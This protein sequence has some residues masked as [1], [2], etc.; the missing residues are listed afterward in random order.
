MPHNEEI[1]MNHKRIYA[2][3][4][5]KL[6]LAYVVAF[7]H[8][9][10]AM[11][12]GSTV[13]VQIFFILSGFFLARKF[14]A[15]DESYTAWSYTA[16]HVRTIYPHYLFSCAVLFCYVFARSMVD[17]FRA[18][19]VHG[20]WET[21][22]MLYNQIPDLLLLQSAYHWHESI[23]YPLWQISALLIAGYFVYACLHRDEILSR[24]ILFPAAILMGTS[25][26]STQD[27]L[28]SNV[29]LIYLPLLRAFYPMCVGVLT[30]Y[31]TQQSAYE[32]LKSN[33]AVFDICAVLAV[34][35]IWRF[36][37]YGNIFLMTTPLIIANCY[38]AES[39]LARLFQ[40]KLFRHCG[41]L[42][43]AVYCNHALISRILQA[44]ILPRVALTTVQMAALYFAMLTLYSAFTMWLVGKWEAKHRVKTAV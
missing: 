37:D 6:L 14:Y 36:A 23:N 3:D 10:M 42:S 35:G 15:K 12:P 27:Y 2:L 32:R 44:Q 9:G 34:L 43:F 40:A 18:P 17:F 26:V 8:T 21:L 24:R 28:F 39:F 16:D 38:D 30:Y 33:R 22:L 31:F 4:V 1:T 13:S 20:V 11:R 5:L 41:K 25:L 7:G 29:G 19:S